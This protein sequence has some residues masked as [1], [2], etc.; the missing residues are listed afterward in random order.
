[1]FEVKFNW[2]CFKIFQS[3]TLSDILVSAVICTDTLMDR[4]YGTVVGI[5]Y[6]AVYKCGIENIVMKI[7]Y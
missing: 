3:Q 5:E 7:A 4:M 1:M 6:R 2:L